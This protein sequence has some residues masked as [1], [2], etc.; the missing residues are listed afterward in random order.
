MPPLRMGV[1]GTAGAGGGGGGVAAVAAAGLRA[2]GPLPAT[3]KWGDRGAGQ[4]SATLLV[5]PPVTDAVGSGEN[6]AATIS[7]LTQRLAEMEAKMAA[8]QQ[9]AS[10]TIAADATSPPPDQLAARPGIKISGTTL[11]P[12]SGSID[13]DGEEVP[14]TAQDDDDDDDDD[15]DDDNDN[16]GDGE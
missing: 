15:K 6:A 4:P 2:L 1:P 9:G 12:L 5:D 8:M 16:G 13:L 14:G 3:A 11:F 10:P 7:H